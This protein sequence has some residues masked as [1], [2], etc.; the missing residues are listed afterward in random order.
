MKANPLSLLKV[1][2]PKHCP[3]FSRHL[4][5]RLFLAEE[6]KST[7]T[8]R[9]RLTQPTTCAVPPCK[10]LCDRGF[11]LRYRACPLRIDVRRAAV[12][13]RH[14]ERALIHAG[15]EASM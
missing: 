5:L 13:A 7:I 10:A 9:I 2:P 6:Y 12:H 1:L 3:P 8:L 15:F 14:D 11:H 4:P